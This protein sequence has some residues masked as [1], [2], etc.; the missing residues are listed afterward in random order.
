MINANASSQA[1]VINANASSQ[2]A[3]SNTNRYD[4][5]NTNAHSSRTVNSNPPPANDEHHIIQVLPT[6][7][8]VPKNPSAFRY[9]P[10][11][12]PVDTTDAAIANSLVK[13]NYPFP[14]TCFMSSFTTMTDNIALQCILGLVSGNPQGHTSH[15][16]LH[17]CVESAMGSTISTYRFKFQKKYFEKYSIPAPHCYKCFLPGPFHRKLGAMGRQGCCHGRSQFIHDLCV[18]LPFIVWQTSVLRDTFFPIIGI[19]DHTFTL[20]TFAEFLAST[21]GVAGCGLNAQLFVYAYL[22]ELND[23]KSPLSALKLSEINYLDRLPFAE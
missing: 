19:E 23:A 10:Y 4:L 12:V 20:A 1:S 21:G 17:D 5:T 8:R 3:G 15:S 9:K 2:A 7:G 6:R 14:S 16:N 22:T 11:P 18:G 13:M